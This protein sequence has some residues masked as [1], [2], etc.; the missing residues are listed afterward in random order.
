[1]INP[2][3]TPQKP[4]PDIPRPRL[5]PIQRTTA[6]TICIAA[7]C[8][9][10]VDY[11]WY[12]DG[13]PQFVVGIADRMV[14]T[15]RTRSEL[16]QP[17]FRKTVNSIMVLMSGVTDVTA[18]IFDRTNSYIWKDFMDD[19][20]VIP[21]ERIANIYSQNL[22]RFL[23][24]RKDTICQARIG[25]TFK[26]FINKFDTLPQTFRDDIL[27]EIND[28]RGI[29]T[30][31][32]TIITGVDETGTHIYQIDERGVISCKDSIGFAII[33][34]G[35]IHSHSQLMRSKYSKESLYY[36]TLLL[37]YMAKK[38]AEIDPWV[39]SDTDIFVIKNDTNVDILSQD[40]IKAIE[41]I[42]DDIYN[43]VISEAKIKISSLLKDKKS[44]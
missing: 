30:G 39:G 13:D 11:L 4:K 12:P 42:Y 8:N 20:Q 32:E 26:D 37:M 16:P 36:D 27:Y 40:T 5:F 3:P 17:K 2:R 1:M 38:Q 24:N 19:P 23:N 31:T 18:E 7:I 29:E 10:N 41:S 43:R 35:D 15:N 28:E 22:I 25:L 21:V 44:S 33:G 14:S 9:G 6:M 34:S